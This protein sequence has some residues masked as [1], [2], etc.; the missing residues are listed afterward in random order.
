MIARAEALGL[1]DRLRLVGHCDDMPAALML[2][3]VVANPSIEPEPFGR[4]V[5]EAQA[6]GRPVVVSDAGRHRGNRGSRRDRLARASLRP[7]GAGAGD[8]RNPTLHP[9]RARCAGGP[10]AGQC[11]R[12]L[13]HRGHAASH[14][15]GIPRAVGVSRI[16]VIKLGALGDFVL[17]FSPFAAIR[18][19]H[20]NAE[21]TLLTTPPFAD[22][23][24]ASPWFDTVLTDTR[25]RPWNLAGLLRL[26]R[27]LRGFDRIYDL[28]T[29]GRSGWYFH[30]AGRPDW[31]G[32]APGCSLPHA[33]PDRDRMHTLERQR[34]QLEMAGITRFP[35][36]DLT[37]LATP[38][39][40]ATRYS[41]LIPGAAPHRP[42]KRWPAERFGE[43]ATILAAHGQP[44]RIVGTKGDASFAAT[45]RAAC[46]SAVD[47]TG[48]TTLL[49]LANVLAS[50][51]LA[52]GNDTGPTHLAAALGIPT[53]ALFSDDSDP[54]LTRPRGRRDGARFCRLGRPD[55]RTGC[56]CLAVGP[57]RAPYPSESVSTCPPSPCPTVPYAA[58]T[59]R[60]RALRWPPPL[61]RASPAPPS[62]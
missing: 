31:S 28:Q 7:G 34:D 25:P 60:S 58:S 30:L 39:E 4:T 20:P 17:A 19:W 54:A 36:P 45:I 9:S 22:L 18:A 3:D 43:L 21:I 40:T 51:S 55:A 44:P 16:L 38:E 32:I 49:Q 50:A 52:I 29:S 33:N 48:R 24:R 56:G 59:G 53:I 47:L 35:K 5:I 42:R 6:M 57:F 11:L 37:W 8:R 1:A 13:H 15:G 62:P 26:R 23:A 61:V 27:A 41:V 2:A 10:G 14:A 12:P 46:P